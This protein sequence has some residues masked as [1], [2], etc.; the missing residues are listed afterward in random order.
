MT[1]HRDGNEN[2]IIKGMKTGFILSDFWKWG[3]SDLLN[4]TLRGIYC[5]FL[6]ATAM[7]LDLHM[8]RENWT[9]WDLTVPY[10]WIDK[11]NCKDELHIEVKSGAFLQSWKQSKLSKIVFSIRPTHV[12]DNSAGYGS[13]SRR[14]SDVY[15]FC[16]YTVTDRSN[17]D[18]LVLDG[19]QFY[20]VPT[21]ILNDRCGNQ[22]SISLSSLEKLHPIIS[23]YAGLKK[24][25]LQ[26]I[27]DYSA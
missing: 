24:A 17:A 22:N 25:V 19:W 21:E 10:R 2:I 7:G 23:D 13:E 18:P 20:I 11:G 3:F 6:I 5:E 14:Q 1:D 4:N 8:G 12:W 15:V 27:E 26:R 16:L 9:P